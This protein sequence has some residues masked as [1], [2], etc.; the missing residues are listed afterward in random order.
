MI[1]SGVFLQK[2]NILPVVVI[3]LVVV[4]VIALTLQASPSLILATDANSYQ[5]ISSEISLAID[6]GARNATNQFMSS[7]FSS[8]SKTWFLNRLYLPSSKEVDSNFNSLVRGKVKNL[9]AGLKNARD[10]NLDLVD[11]NIS[12]YFPDYSLSSEN[13]F[14]NQ[15]DENKVVFNYNIISGFSSADSKKLFNYSGDKS[16]SYSTWLIYKKLYDWSESELGYLNDSVAFII[17]SAGPCQ[18][19]VCSCNAFRGDYYDDATIRGLVNLDKI[20]LDFNELLLK[21]V[22]LLNSQYFGD[23]PIQCGLEFKYIIADMNYSKWQVCVKNVEQN[24]SKLYCGTSFPRK[25]N[26]NLYYLHDDFF[27]YDGAKERY[28]IIDNQVKVDL[29]NEMVDCDLSQGFVARDERIVINTYLKSEVSVKCVDKSKIVS[30]STKPD[31][32]YSEIAIKVGLGKNCNFETLSADLSQNPEVVDP[33]CIPIDNTGGGNNPGGPGT[34]PGG[35]PGSGPGG[36]GPLETCSPSDDLGE[37]AFCECDSEGVCTI[38]QNLASCSYIDPGDANKCVTPQCV[39]KVS[40]GK[41]ECVAIDTSCPSY[42]FPCSVN[43]CN[44]NT[45]YCEQ[46]QLI[47]CNDNNPCTID[48]CYYWNKYY[49]FNYLTEPEKFCNYTPKSCTPNNSVTSCGLNY[50]VS[51][52]DGTGGCVTDTSTGV[53]CWNE[54]SP[55]PCLNVLCTSGA[56]K[57]SE[58]CKADDYFVCSDRC[59]W[60]VNDSSSSCCDTLGQGG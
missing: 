11:V 51:N 58:K 46:R 32:L 48:S 28:P 14:V 47:N 36:G 21:K 13:E 15:L 41:Y 9:F 26:P 7:G 34:N 2:G 30:I 50:C 22:E 45:G 37:C 3:G 6:S 10:Y 39:K 43:E 23:S 4:S 49:G 17:D 59:V 44:F 33:G 18:V 56:C 25:G 20:R 53:N 57:T 54:I 60:G 38:K 42:Y 5:K 12:V 29:A 40:S 19:N 8:L 24:P 55:D 16:L 35:G 52:P 27:G 31:Y 1:F